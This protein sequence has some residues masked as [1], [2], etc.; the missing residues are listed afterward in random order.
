MPQHIAGAVDTGAL[1]VPEAEHAVTSTLAVELCLLRSPARGG[2]DILVD[3]GLEHHV[4]LLQVRLR[5]FELQ[6]EPAERRAAIAADVAGG[7]VPGREVAPAL[8]EREPHQGL[9]PGEKDPPARSSV[10]VVEV[11]VGE[12]DGWLIHG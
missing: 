5:A 12:I 9:D 8:G 7:V 3:A 10:L 6:V 11:D 1:A 4:M 2:R